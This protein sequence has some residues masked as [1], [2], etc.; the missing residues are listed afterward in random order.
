MQLV[1]SPELAVPLNLLAS[2]HIQVFELWEGLIQL[3]YAEVVD[4][5]LVAEHQTC[6]PGYRTCLQ[7][8]ANSEKSCWACHTAAFTKQREKLLGITYIWLG[9]IMCAF[10]GYEDTA[11][12]ALEC[13]TAIT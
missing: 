12:A 5:E 11:S 10:M 2:C 8:L 3:R 6:K 1:K 7:L 4:G 9:S 13:R